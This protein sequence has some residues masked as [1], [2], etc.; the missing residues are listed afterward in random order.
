MNRGS[1]AVRGVTRGV[2]RGVFAVLCGV[3]FVGVGALPQVAAGQ[4]TANHVDAR[5]SVA[6]ES[7]AHLSVAHLFAE[8][9]PIARA[10]DVHAP[11][12]HARI[13]VGSNEQLATWLTVPDP[14]AW[15]SVPIVLLPGVLG[16]S[17]SMRHVT[18]ALTAQGHTVLVIDLLGMGVSDRPEGADY[19][20]AAQADRVIAVLDSLNLTAVRIA[21]HGTSATIALRAAAKAPRRFVQVVSIAGGPVSSQKT[22]GVQAALRIARLL[23][24]PVGRSLARRKFAAQFRERSVSHAWLTDSVLS[25]YLDPLT[26]DLRG[27]LRVLQRMGEADDTADLAAMLKAVKAPVTLL[28][29]DTSTPGSPTTAQQSLLRRYVRYFR[30]DTV[31]TA[32]SMLHEESPEAVVRALTRRLRL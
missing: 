2:T 4:T 32:G 25:Q 22:D 24:T 13:T 21:A 8:H 20:L 28:I 30:T 15:Q 12:I 19:S 1:P 18:K 27:T 6:Q 16:S 7:V 17:F 9:R 5:K 3:C 31:F 14:G 11:V 29:G 10:E 26:S 23:D